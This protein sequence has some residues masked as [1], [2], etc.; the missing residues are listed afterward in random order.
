MRS[1]ILIVAR[2]KI[3]R[4]DN[5]RVEDFYIFERIIQKNNWVK[6]KIVSYLQILELKSPLDLVALEELGICGILA[7]VYQAEVHV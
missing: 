5:A 1:G 6:R 7:V 3:N 4:R 2:E